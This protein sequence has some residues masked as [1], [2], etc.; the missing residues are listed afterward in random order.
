MLFYGRKELEKGLDLIG[1]GYKRSFAGR[2]EAKGA[3]RQIT[4]ATPADA[5]IFARNYKGL[6]GL[7][8]TILGDSPDL[9]D[10]IR[11]SHL[12][13]PRELY[14][15]IR[16]RGVTHLLYPHGQRLPERLNN[17]FLFNELFMRHAVKVRRFGSLRLA[18][19]P[20]EPPAPSAP[21][22]VLTSGIREYPDGIYAV[23]QLDID[24]RVP[25]RFSPPPKALERL[26]KTELAEQLEKVS[27][28]A[29]GRGRLPKASAQDLAEFEMVERFKGV[30]IYLRRRAGAQTPDHEP[31]LAPER[32]GKSDVDVE[33]DPDLEPDQTDT[34][35]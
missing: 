27:G 34:P 19:L 30:E 9:Q 5:I 28:L 29:V 12:K 21:Y 24:K 23:E 1:A 15:V 31:R 32:R 18:E 26:S 7:D 35:P 13:D 3:Q 14:E 8:R 16:A 6:L 2:F 4:A 10:Y 17:V 33:P 20:A 25:D 11:Y 22:L